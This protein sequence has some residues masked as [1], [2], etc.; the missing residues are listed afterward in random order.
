MRYIE[1]PELE[2]KYREMEKL[3]Q[4]L[5]I[6]VPKTFLQMEVIKDGKVLH[7]HKQR[8][9]SWNRNAYNWFYSQFSSAKAMGSDFQAGDLTAKE[10]TGTLRN[11]SGRGMGVGRNSYGA[12]GIELVSSSSSRCFGYRGINDDF[13]IVIGSSDTAESF[14]HYNLQN[15]IA[16][17]GGAGQVNYVTVEAPVKTW[18]GSGR[19]FSVTWQRFFNNNSGGDINVKEVALVPGLYAFYYSSY[20]YGRKIMV[21]RDVL[22]STVVLPNTGQLK[23]TYIISLTYP[24]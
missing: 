20:D 17:G 14:D 12:D 1:K 21:C 24:S 3:G 9:H 23:V 8:S 15:K 18:D 4:E 2:A 5:K 22:D 6:P 16:D 13:G 10:T 7:A 11:D 19:D